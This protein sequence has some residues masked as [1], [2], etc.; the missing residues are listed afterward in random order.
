MDWY[1]EIAKRLCEC[2]MLDVY[3]DGYVILCRNEYASNLM[4]DLI[5]SLYLSDGEEV[6]VNTGYFDPDEDEQNDETD[7]FTGWWYVDLA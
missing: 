1:E 7:R 2:R 4:A 6:I 3:S 5:E